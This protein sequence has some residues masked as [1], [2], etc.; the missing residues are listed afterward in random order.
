MLVHLT[1][2]TRNVKIDLQY[3]REMA[4]VIHQAGATIAHDWHES[5][6]TTENKISDDDFDWQNVYDNCISAIERSDV[7]IIE[8]T[9][10][11]FFQGYQLLM[12]LQQRKPVLLV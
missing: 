1:G 4:D 5:A 6:S 3:F 12:A 10:Y 7:L 11:S 2:G 8:A 9:S